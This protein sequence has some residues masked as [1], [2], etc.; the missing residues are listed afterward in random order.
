MMRAGVHRIHREHLLQQ[1]IHRLPAG[2]RHVAALVVP[3]LKTEK[4]LRLDVVG[5]LVA[6]ILQRLHQRLPPHFLVLL[7]L[8]VK[9][10]PRPDPKLL[11]SSRLFLPL[12]RLLDE[13]R[14]A[15]RII[16]VRHRH[17]PVGHRAVRIERRRLAE[18][19]LRLEIPKPMKLP[20]ALIEKLLRQLVLRRHR[21]M[22]LSDAFHQHRRLPRAF[23]EGLAI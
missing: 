22:H 12:H 8:R 1:R 4:R 18:G 23:I 13:A 9:I 15:L 7:R 19:A 21:E 17:A 11:A 14:G 2:E 16:D 10:R 6:Q 3:K 5:K 20:D